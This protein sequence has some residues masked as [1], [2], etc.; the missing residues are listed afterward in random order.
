MAFFLVSFL[1]DGTFMAPFRSKLEVVKVD[2]SILGSLKVL[3]EE[4]V[5][6]KVSS[7]SSSYLVVE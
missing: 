7:S 3:K 2:W 5:T 1:L 6:E 4:A